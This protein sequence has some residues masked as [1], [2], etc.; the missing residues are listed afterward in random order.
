ML[1]IPWEF[2]RAVLHLARI[3][4]SAAIGR[5]FAQDVSYSSFAPNL[6]DTN[7]SLSKDAQKVL[8]LIEK[9]CAQF[10]S[11][12]SRQFCIIRSRHPKAAA[13]D[14]EFPRAFFHLA[15]IL[16][17]NLLQEVWVKAWRHTS[18][19]CCHLCD[20]YVCVCL[21]LC[22]YYWLW[23]TTRS[24]GWG[25]VCKYLRTTSSICMCVYVCMYAYHFLYKRA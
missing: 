14:R 15:R 1:S 20:L 12:I 6:H 4:E 21:C 19:G 7:W 18:L 5:D 10:F 25:L 23:S 22:V 8:Q 13:A 2:P 17:C 24:L 11:F 3:S 9:L 16:G